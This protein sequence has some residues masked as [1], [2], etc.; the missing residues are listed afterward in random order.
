MVLVD[1]RS[2]T[3][4]VNRRT[5]ADGLVRLRHP[6]L[7]ASVRYDDCQER[8]VSSLLGLLLQL[9]GLSNAFI[10]RHS[11]TNMDVFLAGGSPMSKDSDVLRSIEL[12]SSPEP[13]QKPV[14]QTSEPA[15]FEINWARIPI[16]F[17]YSWPTKRAKTSWIL[18][19]GLI[20]S[21]PNNGDFGSAY[22]L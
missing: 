4:P 21:T 2:G 10:L 12:P 6:N 22:G 20:L 14:R 11:N 3:S 1:K 15:A 18:E 8:L 5:F 16:N 13:S 17:S 7:P 9:F 19:H